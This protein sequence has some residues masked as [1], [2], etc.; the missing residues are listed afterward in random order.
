MSRIQ[1][2]TPI[3]AAAPS[4]ARARAAGGAAGAGAPAGVLRALGAAGLVGVLASVFLVSAG[5]A[6]APSQYVPGRSGGWPAWLAGPL[7]GLGL[8]LSSGR[9]QALVLV[10]CAGYLL[11]LAAA[12]SLP[13]AAL[14]GTIVL[15]NA[16]LV[17]GP[18]LI[19]Q[20]VFGYISYARLGALHGL[21]PYTHVAA[22]APADAAFRFIGWPFK[23]SPYGPLFTLIGYALVPLG[24][25]AGL[26]AFKA[27]AALCALAAVWLAAR[28]AGRLGRSPA[29]TAAFVGLN[30]QQVRAP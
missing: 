24:V 5:A 18:P 29:W 3:S 1:A 4:G 30:R 14:W 6:S 10:M 13:P 23:H 12:R 11:V 22:Q 15:A 25:A 19:S 8:G 7:R 21:D 27:I 16:I 28:A 17:L 20:D 26:W 9:F 2:A